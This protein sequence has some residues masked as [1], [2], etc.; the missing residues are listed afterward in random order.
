MRMRSITLLLCISLLAVG[1]IARREQYYMM[2]K[3]C[4]CPQTEVPTNRFKEPFAKADSAF[5]QKLRE[6][7]KE[8][9]RKTN[10]ELYGKAY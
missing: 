9:A 3:N 7:S 1:C 6:A 4:G 5:I 10:I 2:I 8:A